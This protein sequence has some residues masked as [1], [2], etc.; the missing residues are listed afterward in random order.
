M[1][2]SMYV[3][4]RFFLQNV[5]DPS[6]ISHCWWHVE[7]E[8]ESE[9]FVRVHF[10]CTCNE[11]AN[12]QIK[13]SVML[14]KLTDTKTAIKSRYTEKKIV[15][16]ISTVSNIMSGGCTIKFKWKFYFWLNGIIS[17]I[18]NKSKFNFG[19]P[20]SVF[21]AV[22]LAKFLIRY[23]SELLLCSLSTMYV[24]AWQRGKA[25]SFES[26]AHSIGL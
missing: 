25:T 16:D 12:D 17:Y 15:I 24:M 13:S 8:P 10:A 19:L 1:I 2:L 26:T 20:V 21:E 4:G 23:L 9:R 18:Q 5:L 3:L 22:R 14:D 6:Y 11:Q 7:F